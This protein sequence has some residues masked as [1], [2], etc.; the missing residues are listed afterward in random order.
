MSPEP[1][2]I[3]RTRTVQPITGMRGAEVEFTRLH[4]EETWELTAA[5]AEGL[6]LPQTE[7]LGGVRETIRMY[8][9]ACATLTARIT[10]LEERLPTANWTIERLKRR[11]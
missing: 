10:A 8:E 5:P 11:G 2:Y 1:V 3:C 4:V 7:I 6:L 9:E